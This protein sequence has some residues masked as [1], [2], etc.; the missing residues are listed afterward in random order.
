MSEFRSAGC[1][2]ALSV[3]DVL[4][5]PARKRVQ[6]KHIFACCRVFRLEKAR[7]AVATLVDLDALVV[8]HAAETYRHYGMT[9]LVKG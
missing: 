5:T 7:P 1:W 2:V 9:S 3:T 8:D 4:G 6:D